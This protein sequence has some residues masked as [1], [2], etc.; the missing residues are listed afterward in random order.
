L[1]AKRKLETSSTVLSLATKMCICL[2]EDT[3]QHEQEHPSSKME[4]S[5]EFKRTIEAKGDSKRVALD[6]RVPDKAICIGIEKSPQE[7]AELLQ[8]LARIV[9]SSHGPPPIY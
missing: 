1:T 5:V 9:M 6:T 2:R 7:Q 4:I 3:K 8:F